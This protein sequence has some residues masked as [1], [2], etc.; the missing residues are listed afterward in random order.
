MLTDLAL[1]RVKSQKKTYEVTDRDGMYAAVSRTG[2]IAFRYDYR[3]H[4][5]REIVEAP[6]CSPVAGRARWDPILAPSPLR[7]STPL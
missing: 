7:G 3:L 4:G 5:R 6:G 2:Q 1:K